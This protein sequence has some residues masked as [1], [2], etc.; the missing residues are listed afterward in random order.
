MSRG[1]VPIN[2]TIEVF[3]DRWSLLVLRDIVFGGRLPAPHRRRQPNRRR[4]AYQKH[5]AKR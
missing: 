4:N 2:A 3:G 5:R 1:R